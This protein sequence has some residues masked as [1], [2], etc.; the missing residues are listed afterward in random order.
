MDGWQTIVSFWPH[1]Q[2]RAISFGEGN[3]LIL[4]WN[5]FSFNNIYLGPFNVSLELFTC[6]HSY[7]LTWL[8]NPPNFG[9]IYQRRRG[10]SIA[11]LV[12]R[13]VIVCE[14]TSVLGDESFKYCFSMFDMFDKPRWQ[15]LYLI[16]YKM[17]LMS[18][19]RI[20]YL[21]LSFP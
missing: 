21:C 2:G 10:F 11:L 1:F 20:K 14:H 18:K 17:F 15:R 4:N 8:E 19:P 7:K 13:R 12:Y 3:C 5:V 16:R 6:L 9:G